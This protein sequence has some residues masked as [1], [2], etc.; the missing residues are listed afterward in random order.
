MLAY[1]T[2]SPVLAETREIVAGTGL[3]TLDARASMASVTGTDRGEWGAGPHVQ[4]WTHAHGTDA[5]FLALLERE[6]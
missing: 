6:A 2:C 4:M 3:R 1:V 5:M